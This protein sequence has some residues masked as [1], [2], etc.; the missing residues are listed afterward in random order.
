MGREAELRA[1]SERMRLKRQKSTHLRRM[2]CM[3]ER[4]PSRAVYRYAGEHCIF[5]QM[6]L[7]T[8]LFNTLGWVGA[9]AH[10]LTATFE[11]QQTETLTARVQTDPDRRPQRDERR[12]SPGSRGESCLVRRDR[13]SK[14]SE[15]TRKE[16]CSDGSHRHLFNGEKT[17]H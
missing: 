12:D 13:A 5:T 2:V 17:I 16:A 7:N 8:R 14:F 11:T 3:S 6:Y 10:M 4:R 1:P 9:L 15:P